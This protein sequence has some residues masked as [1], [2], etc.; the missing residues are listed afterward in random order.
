M[1]D[2]LLACMRFCITN[3]NGHKLLNRWKKVSDSTRKEFLEDYHLLFLGIIEEYQKKYT[4]VPSHSA[5][6]TYLP[7]SQQ[8]REGKIK[9]GQENLRAFNSFVQQVYI[10]IPNTDIDFMTQVAVDLTTTAFELDKYAAMMNQLSDNV[11]NYKV[12]KEADATRREFYST[13]QEVLDGKTK[14]T[15]FYIRPK[16]DIGLVK[17]QMAYFFEC[18][19]FK[20]YPNGISTLI[21]GP[22]AAKTLHIIHLMLEAVRKG[23]HVVAFDL[24]NGIDQYEKRLHQALLGLDTYCVESETIVDEKRLNNAKILTYQEKQQYDEDDVVWNYDHK[25]EDNGQKQI[26]FQQGGNWRTDVRIFKARQ[27]INWALG[28]VDSSYMLDPKG[29]IKNENFPTEYWQDVTAAYKHHIEFLDINSVLN[30]ELYKLG[31]ESGGQLVIE[32]IEKGTPEQM[33]ASMNDFLINTD[34]ASRSWKVD[35]KLY[36]EEHNF[37]LKSSDVTPFLGIASLFEDSQYGPHRIAATVSYDDLISFASFLKLQELPDKI[38]DLVYVILSELNTASIFFSN[39]L[40]RLAVIDWFQLMTPDENVNEHYKQAQYVMRGIQTT[41]KRIDGLSVIIVEGVTN[42]QDLAVEDYHELE[43][44]SV[45]S[46]GTKKN[47]YDVVFRMAMLYS[48]KHKYRSL[49]TYKVLL[50]RYGGGRVGFS[51]VDNNKQQIHIISEE[52]FNLRMFADEVEIDDQQDRNE[53]V[54]ALMT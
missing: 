9:L 25:N 39:P 45:S 47:D 8:Y 31:A 21:S 17:S 20:I 51:F 54:D 5:F 23:F 10:P 44:S 34:K 52:E 53:A 40:T 37:D 4:K 32:Y 48:E 26:G 49:R 7:L 35:F 24:E 12:C 33:F 1:K 29:L 14:E 16:S 28:N 50:D 42:K 22:K 6:T 11:L 13:I 43:D 3:A 18:F 15:R 19:P 2:R 38:L 30:E 27:N 36:A 46:S 41:K